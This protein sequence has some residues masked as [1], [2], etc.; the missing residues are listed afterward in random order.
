MLLDLV[1]F[2]FS[3]HGDSNLDDGLDNDQ[4]TEEVDIE[5]LICY[6][7]HKGF[8]Y[9]KIHLFLLKYHGEE[10]SFSTLKQRVKQLGLKRPNPQYN[11]KLVR[12]AVRVL[13][14]GPESSSGY[15]S[16]WH[17]LQMNGMR[18]PRIVIEQ[19]TRELDSAEVQER[20]AHPLK[21]RTYQNTGPN[22]FWHY[23]G[24]DKLKSY[25]F[26]THGCTDGWSRLP[27]G[28]LWHVPRIYQANGIILFR[29]QLKSKKAVQLI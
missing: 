7:F 8:V 19:L 15:R 16:I 29:K 3:Q 23:D 18:V 13:L 9:D 1:K 22:H 5:G 10:M 11:L 6:Y 20:K 12:G 4:E 21:S 2:K 26:P 28:Y 14:D 24:Y 17:S 27:R 25:G